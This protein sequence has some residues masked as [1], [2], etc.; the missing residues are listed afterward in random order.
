MG[1]IEGFGQ[2]TGGGGFSDSPGSGKQVGMG[3]AAKF[4]RAFK[5]R[6]NKILTN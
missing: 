3:N 1:A 6:D 5:G 4:D 2:N